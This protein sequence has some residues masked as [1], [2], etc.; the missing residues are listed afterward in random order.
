LTGQ[1]SFTSDGQGAFGAVRCGHGNRGNDDASTGGGSQGPSLVCTVK[2]TPSATGTQT[3]TATY[4]GDT[5]HSSSSGTF[6]ISVTNTGPSGGS[7]GVIQPSAGTLVSAPYPMTALGAILWA[8][9][10]RA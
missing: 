10:A 7:D 5:Y 4:P 1:V 2:Y 6:Q 8:A 3:I 9:I